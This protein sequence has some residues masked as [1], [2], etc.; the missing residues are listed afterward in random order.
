MDKNT[1]C[2]LDTAKEVIYGD[3][4][5]TYGSPD[6]NLSLIATYWTAYIS[7]CSALKIILNSEDVCIMMALLKLARLANDPTHTDS[8][9]DVCGYMALMERIQSIKSTRKEA[10]ISEALSKFIARE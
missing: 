7:S 6:K 3:R 8:Q 4:E 1:K 5:K 2:I 9:L 10:S